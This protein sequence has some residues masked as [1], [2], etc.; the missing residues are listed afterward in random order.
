MSKTKADRNSSSGARRERPNILL[1]TTDQQ[2]GDCLGIEGHPVLQTLNLDGVG[3]H[4]AHFR[5]AYAECPSCIPSRRS[6]MTGTAPAANGMV[7]FKYSEWDPEHTLPGSLRDA[8]YETKLVGKLHLQPPGKRFGFD[9]MLLTDGLGG[10][11]DYTA[12]LREQGEA[13][14]DMLWDHGVMGEYWAARPDTLP[15]TKKHAYWVASKAVEFLTRQRDRTCPFFLNVSFFDP[16]TPFIPPK[17]HWDRYIDKP[18]PPPPVGDWAPK[19]DGPQKGMGPFA[20]H[21]CIDEQALHDC[22]AAYYATIHFI[23]DQIGRIL[24]HVYCLRDGYFEP[25]NTLILFTS[26]HGEMLGDHNM[27]SKTFP[28]EGSARVP[29]LAW[30]PESLGCRRQVVC[31]TPVGLQDVMPTLLD[32]AGIAI[33]D[34]C[35]GMSVLPIMRG[36]TG[37]VRDVLHGEHSGHAERGHATQYLVGDRFKYVWYT[38]SGR[39]Q[40]FDLQE[41]PQELHDLAP[42]PEAE[43]ELLAWRGRM[44]EF[45]RGR[46][47]GFTDGERLIPGRPHDHLL[48]GYDPTKL[49]PFL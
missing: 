14:P 29:F 36:E 22:R 16:H 4:G 2:R 27:F 6:L 8:G 33:P 37:R 10:N 17:G 21:A 40:L 26:D 30:A 38:L 12:W 3:R 24:N 5:R 46:P 34:T 32:A 43:P 41:D 42:Q 18:T 15:E 7:G 48:P 19:F 1:I 11:S 39:E 25:D 49:Y 31:D 35:T 9:N 44:I 28:Y 20:P 23:D 47:E 13:G 45:L